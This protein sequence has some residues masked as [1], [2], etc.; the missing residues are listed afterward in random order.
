MNVVDRSPAAE[1]THTGITIRPTFDSVAPSDIRASC[2]H[3]EEV[4]IAVPTPPIIE[5]Q[6]QCTGVALRLLSG[7]K[8]KVT[9]VRV[10]DGEDVMIVEKH[11]QWGSESIDEYK[12]TL[13]E[14]GS[15]LM[16]VRAGAI[17]TAY[18]KL[19]D[20]KDGLIVE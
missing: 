17:I 2:I 11:L 16:A 4:N 20:A 19:E 13:D 12:L 6:V 7:P 15:L 10:S 18:L 14:P 5:G 8:A 9:K 1:R 3:Y